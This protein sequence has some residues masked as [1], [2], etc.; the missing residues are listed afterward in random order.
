[1]RG[2]AILFFVKAAALA[3]F[4]TP[5][6]D[7]P[8]EVGHFALVADLADGRGLPTPGRSVLP[9]DVVR[10]WTHGR[11]LP[12]SERW[13]WVAQH[14]PL[15]YLLA[16]PFL[17]AARALTPDPRWQYRAPRLF[18]ALSGAA[19]LLVLFAFFW[20]SSGDAV[21]AF[22]AAGSV[23]FLPMFTHMSSG[24]NH[25]VFLALLCSAAA[26]FAVRLARAGRFADG[27][28]MSAA[29]ALASVTK[30]S[31][32]VVA[33][34]LVVLAWGWLASKGRRRAGE[35]IAVAAAAFSLPALWAL[36][37]YLVF[38]NVRLHPISH[39]RFSLLS[40]ARYL[41]DNPVV[42][43]TFKNFIGLIG[44]TGTGAG[45]VR[46]FQIS[47][48]YLAP[49]LAAALAAAALTACWLW[50][51]GPS[52]GRAA[53]RAASILVFLFCVGWLFS[54]ADGAALPKRLLY[55]LLASVPFLALPGILSTKSLDLDRR[56]VAASHAV[57]L[58][59][60]LAYLVNSWEAYAIYGSLRATNGRYFFAVLPFLGLA[61]LLPAARQWKPGRARDAVLL[62]AL[63]LLAADEAAFFLWKVIPFYRS[64]GA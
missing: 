33:A 29:L 50:R 24:T 48:P 4:V 21:F 7:V 34:P 64:G 2:L 35:G 37:H 30:L 10:D 58:L 42:D 3:L 53:G 36:R 40:L 44:W 51:R 25:D 61:F 16:V 26:L 32:L 14:P 13:N 60:A 63:A 45:T 1:M 49:Y 8:D 23:A 43:H 19:A 59:F 12:A 57:F 46:W 5:L 27:M 15:Y 22:A 18:S 39:E 62:A 28:K 9:E 38:G 52:F 41:R 31:A 56:L 55:A 54:A 11:S 47:G 20:E 17:E 6:W